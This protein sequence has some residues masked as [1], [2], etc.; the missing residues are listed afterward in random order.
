MAFSGN[1]LSSM[2]AIFNSMVN[3][4]L[5]FCENLCCGLL[6]QCK[7]PINIK[8]ESTVKFCTEGL[9]LTID[10]RQKGKI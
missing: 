3:D 5:K 9:S 8:N 10:S 2:A 7:D 4:P 6:V 1:L